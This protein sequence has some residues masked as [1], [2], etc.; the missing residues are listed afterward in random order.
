[1]IDFPVPVAS[2][3]TVKVPKSFN[4][5]NP[6]MRRDLA[7]A[8]RSRTH[9]LAPPPPGQRPPDEAA[10]P[11]SAASG[12]PRSTARSQA[13]RDQ[14][15]HAPLPH[16]PRPRGPRPLGAAV[17]QARPRRRHA[18]PPGRDP[19]QHR[20]PAVRPG[21][22]GADRAR[23]PGGDAART[24]H[25]TD[26]GQ[27]LMRL[28]SELDLVAAESPAARALGRAHGPRAGRRPVGAGLRGPAARRRL[29]ATGAGR[30]GPR[31][32]HRDGQAV[33][34]ARRAR[35][36]PPPRLP[37]PARRRV[38]LGGLPLGRGRRARR[39]AAGDRAGGRRLRPL[40]EAAPRPGRPGR[41]RRRRRARCATPPA[42]SSA[43]SSA[44]WSPTPRSA[45]TDRPRDRAGVG[46]GAEPA[47]QPVTR[48]QHQ[49][50]AAR[51][52]SRDTAPG[53]APGAAPARRAASS[54]STS[55][56][57]P[58]RRTSVRD[59]QPPRLL[60]GPAQDERLAQDHPGT[61]RRGRC[62]RSPR[63]RRR[64]RR[65]RTARRA[66]PGCRRPR[67]RP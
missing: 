13:L 19:H 16:L 46:L 48:L 61:G 9:D 45:T 42:T 57:T 37:A 11:T 15:K 10:N 58:S 5:R 38:R 14:L 27:H 34:P 1:M 12:T 18:A 23:L 55:T 60:A 56:G 50:V 26:Q 3:G 6:Q 22:R 33:G 67:P 7:S 28:Y 24:I 63:R 64:P 43:P 35:A 21:L 36:R 41:R 65:P 49:A 17:V 25:V 66:R 59:D 29:A 20:G 4:G 52:R 54:S 32:H 53:R 8:L 62:V 44:A 39:R 2:V 31:G 40:D 51:T 30:A 47:V